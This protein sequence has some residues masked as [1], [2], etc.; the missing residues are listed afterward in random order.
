VV[1]LEAV[2]AK[3][4]AAYYGKPEEYEP[5]FAPEEVTEAIGQRGRQ[6]RVVSSILAFAQQKGM[7]KPVRGSL[8]QVAKMRPDL[9]QQV[10]VDAEGKV[11]DAEGQPIDVP[12]S[13]VVMGADGRRVDGKSP[14]AT[15]QAEA[16]LHAILR[17][18]GMGEQDEKWEDSG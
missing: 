4:R 3:R 12:A 18:F 2:E 6:D 1:A 16:R 9:V 14:T 10:F 11:V 15:P 7:S 5:F 17:A 8:D 13:A